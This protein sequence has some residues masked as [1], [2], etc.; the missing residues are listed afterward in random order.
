MD[1]EYFYSR[2]EEAIIPADDTN[3]EELNWEKTAITVTKDHLIYRTSEEKDFFSLDKIY[4]L[5]KVDGNLFNTQEDILA[6]NFQK[7]NQEKIGLIKTPFKKYLKKA[8]LVSVISD[9]EVKYIPSYR[10]D[11][12]IYGGKKWNSGLLLF[13]GNSLIFVSND[14]SYDIQEIALR[15]IIDVKKDKA[16]GHE[17]I[18]ILYNNG[19][20]EVSDIFYSPVVSLSVL[21]EF[22]NEILIKTEKEEEIDEEDID[23]LMAI[24]TGMNESTELADYMETPHSDVMVFLETL[25]KRN[26]IRCMKKE[27]E[28]TSDGR[29]L[30]GDFL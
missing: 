24:H 6:F 25:Q 4:N 12:R 2:M 28:L 23:I 13:T 22:S 27:F 3:T 1:S 5:D 17:A 30:L 29:R 18:E 20:E 19:G 15:T 26:L 14:K 7:D 21:Y 9:T 10:V 11:G 16:N 8:I